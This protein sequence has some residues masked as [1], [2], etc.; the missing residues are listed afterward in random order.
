MSA[1][2][3]FFTITQTAKFFGVDESTIHGWLKRTELVAKLRGNQL[4]IGA[5][6]I[7]ALVERM[8]ERAPASIGVR[9]QKTQRIS[10]SENR[11]RVPA[12]EV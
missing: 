6:E 9:R 7:T 10:T 1:E 11:G 5:D 12:K 4:M 3:K 2:T 8:P